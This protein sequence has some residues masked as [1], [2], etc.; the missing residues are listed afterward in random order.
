MTTT[1][2]I[3]ASLSPKLIANAD[4]YYTADLGQMVD[5]IVQNARRAGARTLR[6]TQRDGV[7]TIAD[8]GRGLTAAQAPVLLQLG[9]SNNTAAIET[10]ENAAGVGFFSLAHH[11]VTVRS[12]D[13]EMT[14]PKAAFVGQADATLVTGLAHQPGFTL[15]LKV[16]GESG[17]K[18]ANLASALITSARYSGLRL[19]LE[20]F[21]PATKVC[22]PANFLTKPI[23]PDEACTVTDAHG[24][25]IKLVRRKNRHGTGGVRVNFFGKV[26]TLTDTTWTRSFVEEDVARIVTSSG[27]S[28]SITSDT[29]D[30]TVLVDVRDTSVL[31]LQLPERNAP[32]QDAGYELIGRTIERLYAELL[33]GLTSPNG[34]PADAAVRRHPAARIAPPQIRIKCG[35][36]YRHLD[37]YRVLGISTPAG[38]LTRD[39]TIIPLKGCVALSDHLVSAYV[40]TERAESAFAELTFVNLG[41]ITEAYGRNAVATLDEVAIVAKIDGEEHRLVIEGDDPGAVYAAI[42]AAE[43]ATESRQIDDAA[44]VLTIQGREHAGPIPAIVFAQW[45]SANEVG[46]FIVRGQTSPAIIDLMLTTLDW[47]GDETDFDRSRD[48]ARDTYRKTVAELLGT[49]ETLF[50]ERLTAAIRD[51]AYEFA[52]TLPDALTLTVRIS[53]ENGRIVVQTEPLAQAA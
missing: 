30:V 29:Y 49:S 40:S 46:L 22:E 48:T 39:G 34:I 27:G 16:E 8:D 10:A 28:T 37:Q 14:V 50:R 32:I 53:R 11:A 18:P 25:T 20:G 21:G 41:S 24:L 7:V 9:G 31:R 1:T 44:L 6:V 38:I 35:L 19:V 15:T 13:W 33:S 17:I 3:Q 36:T 47:W 51:E 5:E 43:I 52:G 42:T 26:I 12:H 4:K 45:D 23:E 2:R